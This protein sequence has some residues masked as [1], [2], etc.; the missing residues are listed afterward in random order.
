MSVAHF[1]YR[2]EK[3]PHGCGREGGAEG[4]ALPPPSQHLCPAPSI[5]KLV[6]GAEGG[7]TVRD[8]DFSPRM[9]CVKQQPQQED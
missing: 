5:R 7:R 6:I 9:P 4:G 8:T 3:N 2:N 1:L